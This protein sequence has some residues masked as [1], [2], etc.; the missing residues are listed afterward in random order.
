MAES[1]DL[2]DTATGSLTKD[3][4]FVEFQNPTELARTEVIIRPPGAVCVLK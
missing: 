1:Q 2:A 4:V 3:Q